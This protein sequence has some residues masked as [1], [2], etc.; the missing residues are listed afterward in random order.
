[1]RNCPEK[2][3][4]LILAVWTICADQVIAQHFPS[5]LPEI[6]NYTS[7]DYNWHPKNFQIA[8]GSNQL[9][10][11][12]NSYGIL[13]FDGKMWRKILLPNGLDGHTF[14]IDS[15]GEIYVG[16]FNEF[17]KII[18]E[19]NGQTSYQSLSNKSDLR[20]TLIGEVIGIWEYQNRI[21]L[22]TNKEIY[23][24]TVDSLTTLDRTDSE[25]TFV[26]V[27]RD[28]LY[29]QTNSELITYDLNE[30]KIKNQI[31]WKSKIIHITPNY[32][33]DQNGAFIDILSGKNISNNSIPKGFAVQRVIE[34]ESGHFALGSSNHGLLILNERLSLLYHINSQRGLLS[35]N[36]FDNC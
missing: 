16:S 24:Y 31:P 32:I 2:V 18:Q 6:Q 8:Q 34:L 1:M 21:I 29:F 17:G 26:H 9:I 14:G 11:I 27:E 28:N 13:E 25:Y 22:A 20:S 5:G 4:L 23:K 10:Y 30:G 35:D 15:S 3:F 36:I 7:K 19:N 12:G 33:I